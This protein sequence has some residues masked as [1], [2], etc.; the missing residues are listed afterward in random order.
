MCQRKSK[1][2]PKQSAAQ[3]MIERKSPMLK[4]NNRE[5]KTIT[6]LA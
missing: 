4:G 3:E 5:G 2:Q 6:M 1:G